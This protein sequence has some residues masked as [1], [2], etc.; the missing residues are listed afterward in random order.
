MSY[1][2]AIQN[3]QSEEKGVLHKNY[4]DNHHGFPIHDDSGLFRRLPVLN[5]ETI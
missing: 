4:H 2:T 5:W 3:I 1:C